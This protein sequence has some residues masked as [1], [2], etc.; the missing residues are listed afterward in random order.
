MA[1]INCDLCSEEEKQLNPQHKCRKC[2]KVVCSI[3]CSIADPFSDKEMHR[4]HKIGDARCLRGDLEINYGVGMFVCPKCDNT[5]NCNE[6]LQ[7]H[8]VNNREEFEST[9]PT[10][11]LASDGTLSDAYENCS[12]CGKLL[13]N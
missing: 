5:F 8:F 10:M 3:F 13:E 9:F 7:T 1:E 12:L 4:I 6:K 2:Q 11:S